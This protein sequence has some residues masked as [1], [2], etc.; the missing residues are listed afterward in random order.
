MLVIDV[1]VIGS[2]CSKRTSRFASI[3]PY[4]DFLEVDFEDVHRSMQTISCYP[5]SVITYTN[6]K[7]I[8]L[9]STLPDIQILTQVR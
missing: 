8:D 3:A 1:E 5:F 2:S 6:S 4:P 9:T 7:H